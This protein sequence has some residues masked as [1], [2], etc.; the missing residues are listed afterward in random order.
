MRLPPFQCEPLLVII[1]DVANSGK[2]GR[3]LAPA[4]RTATQETIRVGRLGEVKVS[5]GALQALALPF[6]LFV[7]PR[8]H[9]EANIQR[10]DEHYNTPSR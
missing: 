6:D 5:V 1:P 9:Q 7:D 3:A 8:A 4:F 2:E 10:I